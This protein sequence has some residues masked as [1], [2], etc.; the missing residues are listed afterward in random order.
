VVTELVHAGA[1][2]VVATCVVVVVTHLG[3][4]VGLGSFDGFFRE[5]HV[6]LV[7][8]TRN[9]SVNGEV[10]D[11][12]CLGVSVLR[13]GRTAVNSE[14]VDFCLLSGVVLR[15]RRASVNGEVVDFCLLGLVLR[16][17]RLAVDSEVVELS[18]LGVVVLRLRGASVNS[19]VVD[20]CLLGVELGSGSAFNGV[21]VGLEVVLRVVVR[22]RV[23]VGRRVFSGKGL[24]RAV[25]LAV[26]TFSEVDGGGVVGM[27]VGVDLYVC[28]GS[29]V[30]SS[31]RL[32]LRR[33]LVWG[34][35]ELRGLV[36]RGRLRSLSFFS[37]RKVLFFVLEILDTGTV[38]MFF[39]TRNTDLFFAQALLAARR[40]LFGGDRDRRVL[41]FPSGFG[42]GLDLNLFVGFGFGN[43]LSMGLGFP[44]CRWEDAE[45]NGDASLKVQICDFCWR[46]RSF[47]FNL[48]KFEGLTRSSLALVP[49][50][51][52]SKRME[53]NRE[54]ASEGLRSFFSS[55]LDEVVF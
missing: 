10:V 38:V 49:T 11:L 36:L 25:T 6:L 50:K 34:G 3:L 35:F 26:F 39:F 45:G 33:W 15:A 44:I 2:R 22:V 42:L 20:F 32:V 21:V 52:K 16:S 17:G 14:V 1:E 19:K 7:R 48:P 46:E 31:R 5:S 37:D 24:G 41:T 12:G 13:L 29:L 54:M 30:L 8:W 9:G 53:K 23:R 51:Q 43:G 40:N 27:T 55:C 4:F 28:V 18:L 47:S